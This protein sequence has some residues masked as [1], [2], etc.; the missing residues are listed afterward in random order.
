MTDDPLKTASHCRHYAMCKIDYLE[1]G[2]CPSGPTHHYVAYY[3]QGRMDIYAALKHNLIPLTPALIDI[4][5]TCNLCGICDK[6]CHFATGL[7]PVTVMKA[8]KAEVEAL[9]KQKNTPVQP[10]PP[11][12]ILDELRQIVGP[13]HASNDP[14]I[15]VS[16]ANDPFP[17]KDLQMP[18][19]AVLPSSTS[20]VSSIA[21]LAALHNIPTVVRGNGASVYGMVFTSGIV[22]DT[23]RMKDIT[24]DPANYSATVG[25]GVTSFELQSLA[26]SHNLRANTAE[27]AAT[28][29]GNIICT[30]L[31]STWGAAYGTFADNFIDME[32]VDSEG[33]IFHLS[34]PSSPNLYA[35]K[36]SPQS[37]PAICTR[38]IVP[39]YPVTS[40]E[41]S[42][43]VPFSNLDDAILFARDLNLRRIGLSIAVLGPH[44]IATFLSPTLELSDR[45]KQNLPDVFGIEYAVLVIADSHGRDAIKK[46]AA[47]VIDGPLLRKIML[48]LPRFLGDDWLDLVRSYQGDIPP[49]EI[50]TY[51]EAAPLIESSLRP[52]PET[53]SE[54]IDPDLRPFYTSLYA[55]P[56]YTDPAWLSQNR[57]VSCRMGR[58]KHIFAFLVYLPADDIAMFNTLNETFARTA[59]DLSINHDFGFVTPMDMG[60]R[61]V[62]EYDYYLD[63]ASPDDKQK[64]GAVMQRI[65]PWLDDL[66]LTHKGLTWIKT[67]FSQ[68]LVRKEGFFY[69]GFTKR[70]KRTAE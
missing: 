11:D 51:P 41:G 59:S 56:R 30:G 23:A 53:A 22:I 48:G 49:Y 45:L 55:K 39:L 7:R 69:E 40:D 35:Y 44:Y 27:P 5:D 10:P 60:K 34:D 68:G 13:S 24:I 31:F 3:P 29:C 19:I 15:L 67:F 2:L 26:S 4:A 28:V 12:P 47:S 18:R 57:I 52:S 6:Q 50:L 62:F 54:S 9:T 63:Q 1:T 65:V 8:L 20:E 17:L 36:H 32:L 46:M 70:T 37:P 16:Y 61:A 43:L 58:H 66:A 64:A 42:L 14:A 21:A 25:A 38:A 33:R